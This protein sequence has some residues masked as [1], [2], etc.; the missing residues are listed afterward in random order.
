MQL[1]DYCLWLEYTVVEQEFTVVAGRCSLQCLVCVFLL[2]MC[3]L[4]I[5]LDIVELFKYQVYSKLVERVAQVSASTVLI[6]RY[7]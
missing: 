1:S 6:D 5:F 2:H 4:L 3:N 7:L